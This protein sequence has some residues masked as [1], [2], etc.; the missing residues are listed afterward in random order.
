MFRI[1]AC[2]AV[3]LAAAPAA[4]N[5]EATEKA[6]QLFKQGSQHFEAGR[7]GQ[8]LA[9]FEQANA[10]KPHPLMLYNIGQVFEE[11]QDLRRAIDTWKKY[12]GSG[13][14]DADQI[15]AKIT[16]LEAELAEFAQVT[17]RTRPAGAEVWI[18]SQE[19]PSQGK[20]PG[21]IAVP[22]GRHTLIFEAEGHSKVE[23]PIRVRAREELTLDV[24]L[25]QILPVVTI[26]TTPEGAKVRIDD[27]ETASVSPVSQPLPV[28]RHAATIELP[29]YEP[30]RRE[31]T[32]DVAH[33]A[34]QPLVIDV[35]LAKSAPKGQLM[36]EVDGPGAEIQ[37][38]GE[39][40]GQSPLAAPLVLTVGLH[41]L[42][43]SVPGSRQVHEEMVNIEEGQLFR[44]EVELGI[45]D[46][47]GGGGL[48]GKTWGWI[49]MGVGG[50]VLVGGAVTGGIALGTSGDLD[51]CRTDR[52]CERTQ[53][54]ADLADDVRSQALIGDVLIGTG[55]A[56]A[57]G[58]LVLY[59]LSDDASEPGQGS[60]TVSPT[61][62]GA[63]AVGR[64]TF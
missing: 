6:K 62:G 51:D 59:L 37:I 35:A 41:R 48:S 5:D 31:F 60:V 11:M 30:V 4:A 55:A 36:V 12:L 52:T 40:V 17:L 57:A 53:K 16:K 14:D 44:T 42:Q 28:G 2:L 32:L 54:E 38:D 46:S 34:A 18:D 21:T 45:G 20:T 23:R 15:K 8:A 24:E 13:P 33:T 64:W 47:A 3:L 63:A 61:A 7:L 19:R 1:F 9:A 27:S 39:V 26:R 58:G 29:G 25:P 43:V 10:I 56:I 22:P 50:A 49:V